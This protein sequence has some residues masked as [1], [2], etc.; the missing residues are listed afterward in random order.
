MLSRR[1]VMRGAGSLALT[2][3]AGAHAQAP[4]PTTRPSFEVPPGACD[5]H[6]HI[7][8]DPKGYPM[9]PARVYTPPGASVDALTSLQ[10]ALRFD[11]VVV[12]QPSIYGTDNRCT[13]DAVRELGPRARGIAVI[14]D[15]VSDREL[16]AMQRVGIRGV[17]LNLE[18]TGQADPAAAR[19]KFW[20]AAARISGRDWHIQCYTRLPVIEALK[21]E[22]GALPVPVVLDH[23]G[24]AQAA[25]GQPSFSTLLRLLRTGVVY[26]K[27]S[28]VYRISKQPG[29][30]DAA[31]LARA[32][33]EARPDRIL[34]GTD[35]PHT[36]R[37]PGRGIEDVTPF[38]PIDD[39]MTLNLLASWA[40]DAALRRQILVDNPAR[41]YQF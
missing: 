15:N 5:C 41:L 1:G 38:T 36:G 13:L 39:G 20:A 3:G 32:L 40:P 14:D 12:V 26:V 34:W 19:E 37:V 31:P 9:D 28:A 33:I 18:T 30:A 24:G 17:R 7:I 35:W 22:F 6:V 2:L 16:D 8:G 25:G 4:Q 29:Y 27:I 10:H 11:R 21:D 23:F